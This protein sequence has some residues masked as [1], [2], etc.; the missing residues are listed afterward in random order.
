MMR[1]EE[2]GDFATTLHRRLLYIL[3]E[4]LPGSTWYCIANE[5]AA[6]LWR[7]GHDFY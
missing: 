1:Y 7:L 3:N 4:N 2:S 6:I 5:D